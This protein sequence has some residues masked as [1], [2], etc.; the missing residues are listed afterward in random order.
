MKKQAKIYPQKKLLKPYSVE[1]KKSGAKLFLF[2]SPKNFRKNIDEAEQAVAKQKTKK[3]KYV[4]LI[5]FIINLIV[6]GIILG[7]QLGQQ[8]DMSLSTL[9]NST[10]SLELFFVMILIWFVMQCSEAFRMNILIRQSTG[11]SRPFLAYKTHAYGRYYDC[12]TPM[13]SGGQAFQI[14]YMKQRGLSASS[15]ISVPMGK[16]VIQTICL[17][18]IW[19]LS[20]IISFFVDLGSNF[21]YIRPLCIIGWLA[22]TLLMTVVLLLSVNQRL[23]KKLVVWVLRLLQKIKIVKDYEKR[24]NQVIKIVTDFQVT[25]KSY[26][27]KK[28]S[29]ILQ[30]GLSIFMYLIHYSFPFLVYSCMIGYFDFSMY[31]TLLLL[32]VLIDMAASFVPLPG[33]TGV[34]EISFTALFA[35]VFSNSVQLTW[36][37][38]IWRIMT[39]FSYLIQG[40]LV[41]AYDN[42]VG[43]KKYKW[44]KKK[45]ELEAESINFTEEKLHEYS[46][47]KDKDKHTIF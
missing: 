20:V 16:Y 4:N 5:F 34:S 3:N 25:I 38:L 41:M 46:Q 28:G 15:A 36:A 21:N 47:Q 39:Y 23:G 26:A 29:F 31:F 13:A 11:R 33:G 45:W 37:L 9:F 8:E 22:N 10:F 43:N 6:I 40:L 19:T 24:Y 27:K 7:V 35:I 32:S 30:M 12:V 14:F 1:D 44:L 18:F 17:S 42:V 2:T